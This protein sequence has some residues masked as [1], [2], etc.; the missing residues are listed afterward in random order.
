M[1]YVVFVG[2]G[3]RLLVWK[4]WMMFVSSDCETIWRSLMLFV[5]MMSVVSS[6]YVYTFELGACLIMSLM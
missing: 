3:T 5:V 1:A 6:A 4:Y 2:F